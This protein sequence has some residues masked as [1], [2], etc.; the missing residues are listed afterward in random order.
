MIKMIIIHQQ[1]HYHYAS[2]E[3][4]ERKRRHCGKIPFL[5]P[6]CASHSEALGVDVDDHLLAS[7]DSIFV[8]V[9]ELLAFKSTLDRPSRLDICLAVHLATVN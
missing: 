2:F 6:A 1:H 5:L 9:C 4:K 7:S 3:M 8:P